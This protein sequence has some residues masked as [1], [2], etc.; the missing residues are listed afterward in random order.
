M[1]RRQS[2]LPAAGGQLYTYY[3]LSTINYK[4]MPPPCYF[5][6]QDVDFKIRSPLNIVRLFVKITIISKIA[7]NPLDK[8]GKKV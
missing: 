6:V 5:F 7:K 3:P 1:N 8:R 2:K 4:L